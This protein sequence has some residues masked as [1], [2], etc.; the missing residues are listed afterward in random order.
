MTFRDHFSRLAESYARYRPQYPPELFA[1][2]AE[3]SPGRDLAWD[4]GTGSGQAAV[5]LAGFF[6]HVHATDASPEQIAQAKPH[7]LVSYHVERAE[8]V[9]LPP[10]SA[11]LVTVAVAVHWF[12]HDPFYTEVRRV[13]KPGGLIAVWTYQLPSIEP[14][15]DAVIQRYASE[16][17]K[18]CWPE[19]IRY[20]DEHYRTLPFPFTE[21]EPPAFKIQSTWSLEQ[22]AGFL[23]SWSA[24][25]IYL[26]QNGAHPLEAV[27]PELERAWGDVQQAHPLHWPLHLRVGRV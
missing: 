24:A 23:S 19:R 26:D 12:D 5:Q 17:L 3:Q 22:L 14:E 8:A 7:P 1:Y 21:L 18:G 25:Q 27:Y 9:S 11:D 4:C 10:A 6:A 16:I 15:V 20:V 2:L 13:L